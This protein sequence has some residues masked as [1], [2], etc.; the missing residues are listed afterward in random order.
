MSRRGTGLGFISIAAFLYSTRFIAA[1]IFG[2]G[3]QSW[4]TDLF[5]AMLGYVDQGLSTV[6]VISLIAGIAYLVWAEIADI[7]K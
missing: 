5:S 3:V 2:S 7:R 1:A 6:S 4:D